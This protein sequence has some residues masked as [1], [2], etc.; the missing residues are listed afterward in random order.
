[1]FGPGLYSRGSKSSRSLTCHI[2]NNN[3]F[4][5]LTRNCKGLLRESCLRRETAAG[6]TEGG[7]DSESAVAQPGGRGETKR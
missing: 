3:K 6:A 7:D 5:L 4:R 1:M 2:R